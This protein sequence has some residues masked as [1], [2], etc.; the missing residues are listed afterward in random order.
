MPAQ[1]PGLGGREALRERARR[2]RS[3]R[4]ARRRPRGR[5][6]S[7][8]DADPM[9]AVAEF[10][11]PARHDEVI[12]SHAA[13]AAARAGCSTTSRTASLASPAS[14]VTHVV[15]DDLR[16]RA[17]AGA[18]AGARAR[19]ARPLDVLLP[20]ARD[21]SPARRRRRPARRGCSRSRRAAGVEC[22]GAR[23]ATPTPASLA[24][25]SER[26]SRAPRPSVVRSRRCRRRRSKRLQADLRRRVQ[27][28]AGLRAS[29]TSRPAQR[30]PA[31]RPAAEKRPP[32]TRR[33]HAA[34]A[35]DR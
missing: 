3:R 6:A 20:A 35:E 19:A 13:R 18:A 7:I 29:S 32:R 11:D 2:R 5:A 16:P 25:R 9:D 15:A 34:R 28:I 21:G 24:V 33:R 12:V 14:P 17:G 1:G 22:A 30:E 8:G 31:L 27:Q 23:S 4:M 26:A 10:F